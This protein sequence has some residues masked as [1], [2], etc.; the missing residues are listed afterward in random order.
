M[1]THSHLYSENKSRDEAG[2]GVRGGG[3]AHAPIGR[4]MLNFQGPAQPPG[5]PKITCQIAKCDVMICMGLLR[6]P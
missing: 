5:G 4:L 3:P 2:G 1:Y 6:L